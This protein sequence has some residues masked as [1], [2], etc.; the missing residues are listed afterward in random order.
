MA[1]GRAKQGRIGREAVLGLRHADGQ[2]A[3]PGGLP[4][5]ELADDGACRLDPFGA[6]D[7][8]GHSLD[9]FEQGHV[10]RVQKSERLGPPGGEFGDRAGEGLSA[11]S[12]FGPVGAKLRRDPEPGAIGFDGRDLGGGVGG[13]PV[14]GDDD[15]QAEEAQVLDMPAKVCEP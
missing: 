3:E 10:V 12:A 7:S 5:L 8:A 9:L 4:C 2:L 1:F 14:D 15:R 11:A 6:V 13:E